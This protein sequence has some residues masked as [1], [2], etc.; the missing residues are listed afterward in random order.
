M[1]LCHEVQDP[2]V[3]EEEE[4]QPGMPD[5]DT[6]DKETIDLMSETISL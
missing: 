3:E 4:D 2:E 6:L 1:S 5:Q